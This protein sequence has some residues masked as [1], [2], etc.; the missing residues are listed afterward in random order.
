MIKKYMKE[1]YKEVEQIRRKL[2]GGHMKYF[3]CKDFGKALCYTVI[4]KNGSYFYITLG[5]KYIPN[6]KKKDMVFIGVQ[7]CSDSLSQSCE[8]WIDYVDSDRGRTRYKWFN[9][10]EAITEF[11]RSVFKKYNVDHNNEIDT[12]AWD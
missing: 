8:K 1:L 6:I 11:E 10:Y 9:C 12:G 7:I 5:T 4:L 3:G 2:N